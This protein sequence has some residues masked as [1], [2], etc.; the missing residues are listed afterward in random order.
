MRIQLVI[1]SLCL[2]VLGGSARA[3]EPLVEGELYEG[4]TYDMILAAEAPLAI[5][6]VVHPEHGEFEIYCKGKD[7]EP[8]CKAR[9]DG[10]STDVEILQMNRINMTPTIRIHTMPSTTVR[11][12][13]NT[14]FGA[15]LK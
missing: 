14:D 7:G 11:K 9:H 12:T 3:E 4:I 5:G 6:K 8:V 2:L 1:A 13:V 10:E 15:K